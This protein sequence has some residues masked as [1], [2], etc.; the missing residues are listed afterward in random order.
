[1]ARRH[2]NGFDLLR[3]LAAALVLVDHSYLLAGRAQP[4]IRI[5]DRTLMMGALGVCVFFV[6]SGHLVTDSWLRRP[7]LTTFVANR[8]RRIWPA[9]AV[10]VLASALLLGPLLS[11]LPPREYF[12]APGTWDYLGTVTLAPVR[13]GL[14]GALAANPL[15]GVVNGALWTLPIEVLL[16]CFLALV[17]FAGLL[18]WRWLPLVVAAGA[19]GCAALLP[20]SHQIDLTVLVACFCLGAASRTLPLPFDGRTRLVAVGALAVGLGLGLL[21]MVLT[22]MAHLLVA[23]GRRP[24]GRLAPISRLGDPSYGM[25]I[26]GYPVQQALVAAGV[27]GTYALM[28][29]SLLVV[30]ALGYLSWHGLEKRVLGARPTRIAGLGRLSFVGGSARGAVP[31]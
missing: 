14:P 8:V 12:A 5:G 7:L 10:T 19:F 13:Y 23:L 22:A 15:P 29:V 17:G 21:P 26:Y 24:I 25:Y 11:S 6:L 20:S 9:L 30:P 2:G 4:G 28:G 31:S 16:Y 1:M 3:L 27:T 18:R